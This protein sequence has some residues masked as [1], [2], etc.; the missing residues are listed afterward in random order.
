L[1]RAGALSDSFRLTPN[2]EVN[3]TLPVITGDRWAQTHI[4]DPGKA[5]DLRFPR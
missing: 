3:V 1:G 4:E 2:L 5:L